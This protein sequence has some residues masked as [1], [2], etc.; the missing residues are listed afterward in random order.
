MDQQRRRRE[1]AP[2]NPPSLSQQLLTRLPA[3]QAPPSAPA[4]GPLPQPAWALGPTPASGPAP[5][6]AATPAPI[7][8]AAQGLAW[9]PAQIPTWV[10]ASDT[11]KLLW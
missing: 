7:R 10:Q 5:A 3:P 4:P 6:P 1:G 8:T 9:I 2:F 11:E